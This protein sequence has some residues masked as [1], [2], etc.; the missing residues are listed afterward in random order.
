MQIQLTLEQ[1]LNIC[2]VF[3]FFPP[4]NILYS[5]F[6][7]PGI[8]HPGRDSKVFSICI[9]NAWRQ[10]AI[11]MHCLYTIFSI[12]NLIIYKFHIHRGGWRLEPTPSRYQGT[13]SLSFWDSGSPSP[14]SKFNCNFTKYTPSVTL[15]ETKQSRDFT[16]KVYRHFTQRQKA[17]VLQKLICF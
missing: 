16:E 5:W 12:R 1:Q 17:I 6:S 11:C 2:R 14:Y 3:F 4:R 10:K 15:L 8:S 9:G 7:I 13:L